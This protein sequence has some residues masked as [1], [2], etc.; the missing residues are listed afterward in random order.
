MQQLAS[1]AAAYGAAMPCQAC[2]DPNGSLSR[3][4]VSLPQPRLVGSDYFSAQPRIVVLML[5]PGQGSASQLS[6][7][8]E[9]LKHLQAYRQGQSKLENVFEF[10]NSHMD[11]WGKS[12]GRFTGFYAAAT[13]KPIER[14]AF[15][16]IALCATVGNK[17]PNWML[18]QC[19]QLHTSRL[20]AALA[21]NLLLLSG[22]NLRP[23]QRRLQDLLP[24][25]RVEP[26]LHYAHR[27]G[28]VADRREY[29]RV[30]SIISALG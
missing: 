28:A 21:P 29:E 22:S 30:S 5:N 14:L 10:Q 19:F 7:N 24:Q 12:P 17:Y 9:L 18:K 11:S 23:F 20:I 15:M 1:I 2:F 8:V 13:G 3:A 27:G 16:N 25:C 26:M 4:Y 6:D